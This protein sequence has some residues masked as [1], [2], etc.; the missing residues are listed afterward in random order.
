MTVPSL[1]LVSSDDDELM[2]RSK[3]KHSKHTTRVDSES[4][5]DDPSSPQCKLLSTSLIT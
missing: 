5:S 4:D 3:F 2:R 1:D